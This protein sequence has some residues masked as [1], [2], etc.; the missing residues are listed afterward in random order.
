MIHLVPLELQDHVQEEH[1]VFLDLKPC[2]NYQFIQYISVM[3][4]SA[5]LQ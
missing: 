2:V 5:R 3:L 1:E 4:H